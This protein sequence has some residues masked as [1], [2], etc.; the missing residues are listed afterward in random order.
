MITNQK[1]VAAMPLVSSPYN[2]R[3]ARQL[4][5]LLAGVRSQ[6]TQWMR[7]MRERAALEC[8]TFGDEGDSAASDEHLEMTA[9]MA[10]LA[11][12]RVAA[13]ESALERLREGRYGFCAE[14]DEE[15][16]LERLQAM[17]WTELCVDCQRERE[18]A[19]R[20]VSGDA[21]ILWGDE[22]ERAPIAGQKETADARVEDSEGDLGGAPRRRGRPR[23]AAR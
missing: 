14:C 3:R 11:G 10:E 21:P 2:D 23:K 18:S 13:V 1:T 4:R 12:S 22:K 5:E 19:A 6:E 16:P 15:I 9:S 7:A 17:P 8:S 20:H